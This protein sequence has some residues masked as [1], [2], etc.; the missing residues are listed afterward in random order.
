L[1]VA[2]RQL[3]SKF[4]GKFQERSEGRNIKFIQASKQKMLLLYPLHL[5]W[6]KD[7]LGGESA[8]EDKVA[9]ALINNQRDSLLGRQLTEKEFVYQLTE[10]ISDEFVP[11][12][13]C[14]HLTLDEETGGR[15]FVFCK[16]RPLRTGSD[17]ENSDEV[18]LIYQPKPNSEKIKIMLEYNRKYPN[19]RQHPHLPK[20]TF[21]YLILKV[22][23]RPISVNRNPLCYFPGYEGIIP[24]A[25][26]CCMHTAHNASKVPFNVL[27]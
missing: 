7:Y 23:S 27:N 3:A 26:R 14:P 17:R 2:P 20:K 5:K 18:N 10:G 15:C 11:M 24:D 12:K 9:R 6:I 8:Q 22:S 19:K 16:R 25:K 13:L 1:L 21:Q 4:S